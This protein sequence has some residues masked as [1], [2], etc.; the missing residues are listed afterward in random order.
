[1]SD[2][3]EPVSLELLGKLLLDMQREQR[4]QRAEMREQRTLLVGLVELGRRTDRHLTELRDDLE[5]MLKA[6]LMGRL[7]HFET[8]IEHHISALAERVD[9]LEARTPKT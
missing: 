8:R 6:E 9:T 3:P 2:Q 1:M 4:A 7:G 5:L